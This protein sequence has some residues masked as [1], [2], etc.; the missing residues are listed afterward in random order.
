[1]AKRR[2][3]KTPLPVKP[4]EVS[5]TR[6]SPWQM[7]AVCIG[8]LVLVLTVYFAP[9]AIDGLSPTGTDVV[10]GIGKTHQILENEKKTG[11][12]ALWN[13]Y[14]FSG[15]P[16]YQR[17]SPREAAVDR[18]IELPANT[19]GRNAFVYYVVGAVGL[20]FLARYWGA[21]PWGSVL[22]SLAFVLMP[23][24][25]VLIQAGHFQKFRPV[26]LMPW[27]VLAFSALLK[28]GNWL[29]AVFF[30][31]AF[32]TL[33]RTKHYQI[34]YYA[35]LILFFLGTAHTIR[36]LR[37]KGWRTWFKRA[38]L[39]IAAAAMAVLMSLQPLIPMQEYAGYSIRGGA[40]AADPGGL[41]YDYAT[42]WSFSPKEM[43]S[44]LIPNAFGGASSV[45]YTGNAV[46]QFRNKTLP[47]YWGD[48]PFTEGGDYLGILTFILAAIG[49]V[50]AF[51]QKRG[52]WIALC[53]FLPFAFLLSFGRHVPWLFDLFFR[54]APFFDKFR[55]PSMILTAV[56]FTAAVLAGLGITALTD[57][58]NRGRYAGFTAGLGGFLVLL[59]L[60]PFLF[61][62]L[63]SFERAGEVRQYGDQIMEL[64]RAARFDLMKRDAFRLLGFAVAG[65]GLIWLYLKGRFPQTGL[66][67][68]LGVL[69]LADLAWIGGRFLNNLGP[70]QHLKATYFSPNDTN[71]FL[72]RDP[73]VF[74]VFPLEQ[75][76]FQSN[77][78]S[79]HHQSVG[80]Y[81]PA[82]LR[83]YQDVIERCVYGWTHA[84]FPVNWNLLHML[85]AK[86]VVA[87]GRLEEPH[88]EPVFQDTRKG[89]LTYRNH[90]DL[91]RAWFVGAA[92]VIT[93]RDAR[94][95]R[96]NDP[97][98]RP[99]SVAVLETSLDTEIH[100][101]SESRVEVT[102][103]E[104]N[105]IHLEVESDTRALLVVS[106]IY[107]PK[108]WTATVDGQKTPI[109]K[110][111]HILRALVVP[112]G[113]HEIR[114][115]FSP[116]SYR[117]AGVI[118]FVTNGLVLAGLALLGVLRILRN[119]KGAG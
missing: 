41:D 50:Y 53:V 54:Y 66:V 8:L 119:R 18:I 72:N 42:G 107:Y 17:L 31:L 104:P 60:T 118:S 65:C 114:M 19:P 105:R 16:L 2:K 100:V 22:A 113:T 92:E 24:Y 15:M 4:A 39:L 36:I 80:G 99:D 90:G 89:L 10:G 21:P 32:S 88:L 47:G 13:P 38:G 106:E 103:F 110:A 55:A 59:A 108:G 6:F 94:L 20:F 64:I 76:T 11:E 102:R 86:Y 40:E 96:L 85:N 12:R 68:G 7:H 49:C 101:P 116:E 83:I 25:E 87:G 14:V 71:R 34:V 33:I 29:S 79:F 3:K 48:M 46:P 52:E 117:M 63:F 81:D 35:L 84:E 78:W 57:G 73:D 43:L 56:Y 5:R 74:R 97:A 9:M 82:K 1:M 62:G 69:L 77:D 111:N 61:R 75:N 67:I 44:L 45:V 26:M 58:E 93:D 112:T 37:E 98:F 23:H 30:M 91:G 27:V 51:R 109:Y 28:K 95:G 70:T 115:E